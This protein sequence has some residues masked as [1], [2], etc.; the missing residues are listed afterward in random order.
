MHDPLPGTAC[1][2]PPDNPVQCVAERTHLAFLAE[3]PSLPADLV[4]RLA[5]DPDE[6]VRLPVSLRPEPDERRRTAIDLTAGGL[7]TGDGVRWVRDGLADPEVMRRAAASA[8]PLL[9]RAAA[10]SP[11]L[12]PDLL[13]LPARAEDPTTDNLLRTHHPQ[14]SKARPDASVC[15]AG[16]DVLHLDGTGGG[17]GGAG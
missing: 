14:H 12:P 11:Q 2:R 13:R 6:A 4:E 10:R 17:G 3:N 5:A 1:A 7:D 15:P 8:H 9:Q 16:R